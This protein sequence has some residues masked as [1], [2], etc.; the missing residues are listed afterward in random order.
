MSGLACVYDGDWNLLI[1]GKD[2]DD[3]FKL[4]SLVYG[5]GSDVPAGTWSSLKEIASAPSGGDFEYCHPFL[6][7]PDVYRCFFVEKF[8]DSEAYNRPFWAHSVFDS[9]FT[10]NLWREPVPFNLS[11]ECGLAIAHYGYYCWLSSPS[12]VWELNRIQVEGYDADTETAI[13][14]DSSGWDE[15][16]RVYDRLRRVE[17]RN[18]GIVAQSQERGQSY[19]RQAEIESVRGF[20]I[21]P[22]N[23]GQQLYDVIDITDS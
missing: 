16:D 2:S 18:I 12:G 3:N 8:T 11:S 13:I 14:A 6:D 4:W 19:L 10:E 23:C 7:K 17:D 22:V 5:D 20:I 15:I 9:G 1:T 21:I